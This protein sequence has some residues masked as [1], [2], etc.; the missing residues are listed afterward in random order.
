MLAGIEW[1]VVMGVLVV[2]VFGALWFV[3][4]SAVRSGTHVT[5]GPP[6]SR[7]DR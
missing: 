4:R 7:H 6:P 3:V 2:L 1:L 5:E